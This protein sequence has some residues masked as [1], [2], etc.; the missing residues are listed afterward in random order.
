METKLVEISMVVQKVAFQSLNESGS[1]LV[2]GARKAEN[3]RVQWRTEEFLEELRFVGRSR[4]L[5]GFVLRDIGRGHDCEAEGRVAAETP[6]GS[7]Y[8]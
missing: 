2:G 7:Y 4:T 8:L 5:L 3:P 1:T 6:T